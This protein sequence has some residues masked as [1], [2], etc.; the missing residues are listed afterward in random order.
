MPRRRKD[1]DG[2]LGEIIF[3]LF[4]DIGKT[5][6]WWLTLP[7]ALLLY[8]FVPFEIPTNIQFEQPAE[9]I[10]IVFGIILKALFKY[11]VPVALVF[12]AI[13]SIYTKFKS[14]DLFSSISK[15]GAKKTISELGWKDFEFLL[16]EWF[17]KQG[18]VVQYNGNYGA[19]GGVDIRLSKNDKNYLVQCKHYKSW[20]V[21]VDIVR[22]FF[23]VMTAQK[24]DGG[25][26]ATSGVFTNDA[27][28][29]AQEQSIVLLDGAKLE[30]ILDTNQITQVTTSIELM[31]CPKCGSKL[32]QR[33]G[34]R[35]PFI[36]CT[37]YPKCKYTRNI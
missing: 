8:F 12:G 36:G 32:I 11:F 35:G 3:E 25:F 21:S 5:L 9:I 34:S 15:N 18:Y 33:N 7:I 10:G 13:I 24:A 16:S 30:Q 28:Q 37:S 6:P 23:G 26:I 22:A 19:D 17:K 31:T 20:K 27:K 14:N 4:L 2:G 1:N 29:F